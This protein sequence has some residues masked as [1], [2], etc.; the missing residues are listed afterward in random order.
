V[1]RVRLGKQEFAVRKQSFGETIIE[2][3]TQIAEA[4]EKKETKPIPGRSRR[5][6]RRTQISR[7]INVTSRAHI[8]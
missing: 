5:K 2:G 1:S 6:N 8:K 7:K 3:L 4:L